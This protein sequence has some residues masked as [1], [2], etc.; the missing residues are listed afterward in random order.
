MN[1]K[2]ENKINELNTKWATI[3]M[4]MNDL[5]SYEEGEKVQTKEVNKLKNAK[6]HYL[7]MQ[8]INLF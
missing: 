4:F 7:Y 5:D 1:K 3:Q 6:K 8:R 2:L